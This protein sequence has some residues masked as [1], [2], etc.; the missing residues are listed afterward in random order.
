M[1]SG[2]DPLREIFN[3]ENAV[4]INTIQLLQHWGLHME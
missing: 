1:G 3:G 4:D 2:A